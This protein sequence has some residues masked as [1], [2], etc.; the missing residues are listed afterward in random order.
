MTSAPTQR[1]H[2]YARYKLDGCRCYVCGLANATYYEARERAIMYGTWQPYVSAQPVREHLL[3]LRACGMGLRRVSAVAKVDRKRLQAILTGRPERGTP[4]QEKVRPALAAAVL[5]VEPTLENLGGCTVIDATGTRR[6]L[7]ALVAS[8][9]PQTRL[10]RR[11]GWTDTNF[12]VLIRADHIIVRTALAV[13]ALYDVLWNQDPRAHGVNNQAYSRA[14]NSGA[15]HAWPPPLA[16]DD[17]LIDLPGAKPRGAA[18]LSRVPAI[19]DGALASLAPA[20][21]V[22]CSA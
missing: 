18:V 17:E 11:L 10:A 14:V 2:G 6:R 4:P 1:E 22:T 15:A 19:A 12:A 5:A 16:W 7:Q 8:G 21:A 13:R 9:W 20:E 3:R